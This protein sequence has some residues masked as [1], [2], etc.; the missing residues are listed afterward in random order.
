MSSARTH[1][2]DGHDSRLVTNVTDICELPCQRVRVFNMRSTWLTRPSVSAR[3]LASVFAL[4]LFL[5]SLGVDTCEASC[6]F[7]GSHCADESSAMPMPKPAMNSAGHEHAG[8][9]ARAPRLATAVAKRFEPADC[10]TNEFCIDATT[11]VMRPVDRTV[12]LKALYVAEGVILTPHDP[13]MGSF[14][15]LVASPPPIAISPH[16]LSTSLRI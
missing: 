5:M 6:L 8:Y 14:G 1:L 16:P 12:S 13:V 11:S 10:S 4:A 15:I 7:N 2:S 3:A 9:I